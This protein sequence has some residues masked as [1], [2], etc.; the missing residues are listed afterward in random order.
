MTAIC[1][2]T[3]TTGSAAAYAVSAP[4]DLLPFRPMAEGFS[5][6]ETRRG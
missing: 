3:G 5:A 4:L 1:I 6:A 2:D